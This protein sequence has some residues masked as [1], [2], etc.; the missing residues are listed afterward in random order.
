VRPLDHSEH[1]LD[2]L[3]LVLALRLK[4]SETPSQHR[5]TTTRKQQRTNLSVTCHPTPDQRLALAGVCT[6]HTGTPTPDHSRRGKESRQHS[7][8][9]PCSTPLD[10]L[11]GPFRAARSL[12]PCA[13]GSALGALRGSTPSASAASDLATSQSKSSRSR[14]DLADPSPKKFNPHREKRFCLSRGSVISYRVQRRA[15]AE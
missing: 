14:N 11:I 15:G 7:R 1:G 4:G 13:R 12:G 6:R 3:E 2:A 8:R 9:H 10:L 5:R